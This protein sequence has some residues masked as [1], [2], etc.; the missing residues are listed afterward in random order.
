MSTIADLVA[1]AIATH[2]RMPSKANDGPVTV[3]SWGG[4]FGVEDL[5]RISRGLPAI[6]VSRDGSNDAKAAKR[7]FGNKLFSPMRMSIDIVASGPHETPASGLS[8]HGKVEVL[9]VMLLE[10]LATWTTKVTNPTETA[11][12][13]RLGTLGR[14]EGVSS[15]IVTSTALD[16]MGIAWCRI[17][18][19]AVFE[20][21]DSLLTDF[22]DWDLLHSEH[23]KDDWREGVVTDPTD[24]VLTTETD[25]SP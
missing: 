6:F 17:S 14:P 13:N 4:A 19:V 16:T 15:K 11:P 21:A 18:Y 23:P 10:L 22:N 8:R 7:Q 25:M 9:E 24:P 12:A 2:P 1:A 3:Q 20:H 5:K